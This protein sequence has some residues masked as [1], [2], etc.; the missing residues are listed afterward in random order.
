MVPAAVGCNPGEIFALKSFLLT[1]DGVAGAPGLEGAGLLK[2]FA[3][4]E[5]P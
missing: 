2:V 3:L 4:E 1:E 5:Q